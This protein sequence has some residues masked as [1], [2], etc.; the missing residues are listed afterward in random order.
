MRSRIRERTDV[1]EIGRK[2]DDKSGTEIF[3]TG[4]IDA[5]FHWFGT[6]EDDNDK[7]II[8]AIGATKNGAL[9]R[10]NHAGILSRSDAVW[11]RLLRLSSIL[12]I[13]HSVMSSEVFKLFAESLPLVLHRFIRLV[14]YKVRLLG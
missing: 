6:I 14:I 9:T 2:S 3:P 10:R 8:L 4:R 12:I 1:M 7:F 5:D 11:L 13:R